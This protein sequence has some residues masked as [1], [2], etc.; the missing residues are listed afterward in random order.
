MKKLA[1]VLLL[2]LLTLAGC[3]LN[4]TARYGM[5]GGGAQNIE[6]PQDPPFDANAIVFG[7]RW[8][9]TYLRFA[10][11]DSSFLASLC[12]VR[13]PDF[14]RIGRYTLATKTWDI[15]PHEPL[16][17]YR[18]P[19]FS[20]DG[21]W[22]VTTSAPC[23]A[24]YQ[25]AG[26]AHALSRMRSDGTG[27]EKLGNDVIAIQATFSGNGKK[28]I[29]WRRIATPSPAGPR[30]IGRKE[31]YEM[32]WET[33]NEKE[34]TA[35]RFRGEEMDSQP[36]LTVDGE[37]VVLSGDLF[38]IGIRDLKTG[39]VDWGPE[40]MR[41]ANQKVR[42]WAFSVRDAPL[43]RDKAK[44]GK[45]WPVWSGEESGIGSFD[46]TLDGRIVYN[47]FIYERRKRGSEV[48]KSL[49]CGPQVRQYTRAAFIRRPVE[50]AQ[51]EAAFCAGL[52]VFSAV[53][54]RKRYLVRTNGSVSLFG[55][56][57]RLMLFDSTN[58]VPE[59]INWPRL[60]LK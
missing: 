43:D 9:P 3:S 27:F 59:D 49:D 41:G 26:E 31:I 12:H 5:Y 25:C 28:L 40:I 16:R 24:L 46:M 56:G 2:V 6:R 29:Y 23:D 36:F 48:A 53:S 19:T 44:Q 34:L 55:N 1:I 57:L 50:G 60:E 39:E 18:W 4:P 42:R 35:I 20:P 47:D 7:T 54:G 8:F 10:P 51:D 45:M 33:G 11:D 22:I 38:N 21:K 52:D 15:L 17:T 13:R 37:T 30:L 58:P 14:C 32:D